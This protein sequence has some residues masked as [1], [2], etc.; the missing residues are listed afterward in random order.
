MS[1][2]GAGGEGG[3]EAAAAPEAAAAEQTVDPAELASRLDGFEQ[4]FGGVPDAL[5]QIQEAFNLAGEG[6]EGD[7][8]IQQQ[9]APQFVIDPATGITYD[10]ETGLPA[11]DGGDYGAEMT[12]EDVEGLVEQRA[13]EI[14][15]EA[16]QP[17]QAEQHAQQLAALEEAYPA[18]RDQATAESVVAEARELAE[19]MGNPDAWRD[20]GVLE[21]VF[22]AQRARERAEEEGEFPPTGE[23]EELEEPGAVATGGQSESDLGDKIVAAGG[24]RS[25]W[26]GG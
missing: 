19:R 24:G 3:G 25:F 22:L 2:A 5:A 8:G 9:A 26:M 6:D 23:A 16:V 12:P 7:P 1:V 14:A 11:D 10:L 4:K 17:L 13:R 21:N 18:L 15:Q 20:P